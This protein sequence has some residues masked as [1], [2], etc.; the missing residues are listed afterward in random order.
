MKEDETARRNR[1]RG[2]VDARLLDRPTD[3]VWRGAEARRRAAAL[4]VEA[5]A[6]G[7][8]G[9]YATAALRHRQKT[10]TGAAA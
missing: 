7:T 5:M 6:E 8:A 4:T 9:V 1:C 10:A 2:V 3:A